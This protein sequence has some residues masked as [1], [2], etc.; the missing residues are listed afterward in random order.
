M[1]GQTTFREALAAWVIAVW[2]AVRV[3]WDPHGLVEV[4]IS[5]PAFWGSWYLGGR[6]YVRTIRA[7]RAR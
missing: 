5:A 7:R 6:V 1:R 2:I 4:A 3:L